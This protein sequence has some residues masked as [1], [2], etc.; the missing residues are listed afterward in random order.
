MV[1]KLGLAICLNRYL[2]TLDIHLFRTLH[3]T[4]AQSADVIGASLAHPFDARSAK[5]MSRL[6]LT[7]RQWV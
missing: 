5:A 2:L 4:A 1:S 7:G 6:L 3:R